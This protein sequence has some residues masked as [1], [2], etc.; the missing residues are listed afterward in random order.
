M[1][2]DTYYLHIYLLSIDHVDDTNVWQRWS[3]LAEVGYIDPVRC[4]VTRQP[5]TINC[6]H[7]HEH[8]KEKKGLYCKLNFFSKSFIQNIEI[9][10][11]LLIFWELK[12]S[13]DLCTNPPHFADGLTQLHF[14]THPPPIHYGLA[15]VLKIGSTS[16]LLEYW[17]VCIQYLMTPISL[18]SRIWVSV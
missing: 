8:L 10:L 17:T 12:Q 1:V 11:I 3:P 2:R 7:R 18:L 14:E 6:L 5:S 15:S 4:G 9:Q 16:L 13:A